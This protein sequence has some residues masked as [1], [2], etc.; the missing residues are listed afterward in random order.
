MARTYDTELVAKAI[1]H[2]LE[3]NAENV[4]PIE[5]ISNPENIVL[6]NDQ[7]DMALF[8]K[9][10]KNIYSGHYFFKSRGRQAI[11]AGLGFLDEL[12][13]TCYNIQVLMGLVPLTH[14][15]ARWL[16]R[17]L[18][19]KSYGIE[20]TSRRPYELFIITKKEYNG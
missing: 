18:G 4:D 19:F 17:R 1:K 6:V 2:F 7:G 14:L 10:V 15:G 11:K 20:R 16:T 5:W 13:N 3:D 12:F 9:G 8:E